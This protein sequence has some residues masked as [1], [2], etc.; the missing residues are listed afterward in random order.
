MKKLSFVVA[1]VMI[2]SVLLS[3]CAGA[4]AAPT[5]QAVAPTAAAPTKAP[6]K[7]G[8]VTDTGGIS[9][10]SF[11]ETQWNGVVKGCEE[12]GCTPK[13]IVSNEAADYEPNLTTFATEGYQLVQAAGFF[14]GDALAKVVEQAAGRGKTDGDELDHRERPSAQTDLLPLPS[15]STGESATATS[16]RTIEPVFVVSLV[17]STTVVPV[18]AVTTWKVKPLTTLDT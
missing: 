8:F 18:R 6:F 12:F 10:K 9:D 7:V 3:A 11:N 13:Y 17:T 1:V 2:A 14:L 5:T 16:A 4:T 15:G